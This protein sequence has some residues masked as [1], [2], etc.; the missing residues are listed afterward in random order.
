M[1]YAEPSGDPGR[2]VKLVGRLVEDR[3]GIGRPVAPGRGRAG[4]RYRLIERTGQTEVR[5]LIEPAA[6]NGDYLWWSTDDNETLA[7]HALDLRTLT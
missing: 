2:L 5:V 6:A 1:L 3:H 4:N 7:W